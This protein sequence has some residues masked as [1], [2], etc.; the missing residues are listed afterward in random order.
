MNVIRHEDEVTKIVT[1][2][3]E[4]TQSSFDMGAKVCPT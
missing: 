3:V 1:L 4:V 2:P